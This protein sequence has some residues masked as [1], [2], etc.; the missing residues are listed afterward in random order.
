MPQSPKKE[1][2]Q[3]RRF[4]E[5]ERSLSFQPLL[6][7]FLWLFVF[8]VANALLFLSSFVSFV[9]FVVPLFLFSA[10]ESG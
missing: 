10:A 4:K 6:S 1:E 2:E 3:A 8:F 9:C 7:S 5:Q